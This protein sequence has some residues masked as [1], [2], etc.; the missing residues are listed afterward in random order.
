MAKEGARELVAERVY[1]RLQ[2]FLGWLFRPVVGGCQDDLSQNMF[3][4]EN[5]GL[6]NGGMPST[7]NVLLHSITILET[8]SFSRSWL[9]PY[10]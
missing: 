8:G 2:Q 5:D 4:N 3:I 7:P 9:N 1:S 6:R 10:V